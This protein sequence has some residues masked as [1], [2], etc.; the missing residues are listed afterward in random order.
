MFDPEQQFEYEQKCEQI[1]DQMEMLILDAIITTLA[2][3]HHYLRDDEM[4]VDK[5]SRNI[6]PF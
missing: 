3:L 4:P 5:P 1:A 6:E 2:R